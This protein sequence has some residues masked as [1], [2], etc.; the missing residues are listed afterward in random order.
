MWAMWSTYV[1]VYHR[2][3][4]QK[5]TRQLEETKVLHARQLSDVLT[6]LKKFNDLAHSL[7]V[8]DYNLLKSKK[9]T[10]TEKDAI[11]KK[12]AATW[13]EMDFLQTR[14]SQNFSNLDYVPE[15]KKM[16]E[17]WKFAYFRRNRG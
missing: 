17:I 15:F 10:E 12:R 11:I 9:M 3:L 7:N 4:L 13:G 2:P 6:Y 5:R 16:S 8:L 14:V 1:F